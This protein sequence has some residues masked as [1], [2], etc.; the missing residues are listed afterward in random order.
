MNNYYTIVIAL[1][2]SLLLGISTRSNSQ[3]IEWDDCMFLGN[4]SSGTTTPSDWLDYWN[5]V[6]P[7]NA[8]KWGSVEGARDVMNW[9]A[10][11]AAYNLAKD[12]GLLFKQHVLVWGSQQPSWIDELTPEEQLQEIEEWIMSYCER[13]PAT[14][15]IEVVNEPL[16]AKPNGKDN[17]GEVANY[18]QALGGT[19]TTGY[20]WII[21]SFELAKQYCP[22]AELW[23]NEYGI[24][25]QYDNNSRATYLK[26]INLLKERN[27]VDGVGV[28]AHEFTVFPERNTPE[29]LI[30]ALDELATAELPIYATELDI[31]SGDNDQPVDDDVQLNAYKA[32][33]PAIWKHPAVKGVTLWGYR[34]GMWRSTANLVTANGTERPAMT[35][36]KNYVTQYNSKCAGVTSINEG[37]EKALLF[38]IFPNP[39]NGQ[40]INISS[41]EAISAIYIRDMGGKIVKQIQLELL[42]TSIEIEHQLTPGIYLMEI[43]SIT[44]KEIQRVLIK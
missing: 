3:I 34:P 30:T 9:D 14:D 21:K 36:L 10:L 17:N 13:Y 12:N 40:K 7:E 5:Q 39:S 37:L 8:G 23:I 44:S 4:V 28:Q 6:S 43:N 26:I 18:I 27:L 32:I 38:N 25:G 2:T 42:K 22:N 35:W 15:I 1:T 31:G 16:H 41:D 33:F 24:L 19:G 11:D 20:D 29:N